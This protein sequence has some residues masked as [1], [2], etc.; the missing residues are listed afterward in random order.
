M[1]T[2]ADLQDLPVT[3]RCT[4]CGHVHENDALLVAP[5]PFDPEQ[6]LTG[7]PDCKEIGQFREVC[8][9]PGCRNDATCG[10]P[11]WR[12]FRYA[13]LCGTHYSAD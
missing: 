7:C 10:K 8:Q 13:H 5:N 9:A 3:W 6:T 4:E 1:N 2:E 11:N 12:G